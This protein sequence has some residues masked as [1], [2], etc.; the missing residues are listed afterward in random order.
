VSEQFYSFENYNT[1]DDTTWTL[2]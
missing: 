2:P 1:N